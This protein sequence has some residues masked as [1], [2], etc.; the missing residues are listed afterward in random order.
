[1]EPAKI[2]PIEEDSWETV[3]D[4]T[5]IDKKGVS[6]ADVKKSRSRTFGVSDIDKIMKFLKRLTRKE[7]K[8]VLS[9]IDDIEKG[10]IEHLDINRLSGHKNI[11]RVRVGDIRILFMQSKTEYRLVSIERRSDTTYNL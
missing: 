3:V 6:F 2:V 11:F 10:S 1:M 8:R 7:L 4:F 9:V 5:K